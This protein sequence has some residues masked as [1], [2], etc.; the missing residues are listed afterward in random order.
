MKRTLGK[1]LATIAAV[2]VAVSIVAGLI[3][4]GP[5]AQG[6]LE[7]L[8]RRR[9]EDLK[10]IMRAIDVVWDR[11]EW[12]PESLDE[13]P[14][15]PRVGANTVDPGSGEPYEYHRLDEEIYELCATFDGESPAPGRQAPTAFWSHGIGRQCFKL[16]VD[17]THRR[18][19]P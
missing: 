6:R 3:L 4:V 15:D 11:N 17:T 1:T 2:L 9:I 7:R 16:T 5:P 18:N 14:K 12:L 13:L 19:D 10:G 8:D